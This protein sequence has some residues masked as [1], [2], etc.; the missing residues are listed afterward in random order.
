MDTKIRQSYTELINVKCG[1]SKTRESLKIYQSGLDD[2]IQN[3]ADS[4]KKLAQLESIKNN[5]KNYQ[6]IEQKANYVL[7]M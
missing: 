4:H 7:Y 5:N 3:I 1:L 2:K 6:K